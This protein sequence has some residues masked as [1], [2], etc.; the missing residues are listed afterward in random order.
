MDE[1]QDNTEKKSLT[2]AAVTSPLQKGSDSRPKETGGPPGPEPT[3]YGDLEKRGR[4]ID[5]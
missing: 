1:K 3:R 4:C 2:Q 5:F